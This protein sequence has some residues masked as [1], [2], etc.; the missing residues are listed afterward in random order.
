M[1]VSPRSASNSPTRSSATISSATISS[2]TITSPRRGLVRLGVA[3]ALALGSATCGARSSLDLPAP[4]PPQPECI[5]HEDCP[6][7]DDACKPVRCVDSEKYRDKLPELPAG[8][9]LPPRV[10]FVVEPVL[11]DDDSACTVDACDSA[12]AACTHFP[13]TLDLDDDGFRAPLPGK[14]PGALDA[15]GDDCND[16]SALSF[17]GNPEMCDGVDNDCNGV[18]DDGAEFVP[19]NAEPVRISGMIAPAGPGGL[20]FDGESYLAIY[21]G[22][23]SGFDM[24]ETRISS[25]GAKLEPIETKIALQNADSAG[26]PI[27]WVGDRYG[28]VWQDR[29]DA[30]YEIYFT[31]LTGDGKKALADL[32]LS[33]AFGF[34]I[35][36]DLVWNGNEFIAAWQ[37]ER[38]G[39]FEIVGQRI[40]LD[41]TLVGGNV[42]LAASNG[43]PNEAPNLASGATTLALAFANGAGGQ[44]SVLLRTFD[45]ETL[46]ARSGLILASPTT[47][48]AVSPTVVW[49]DDRYVVSWHERSG[50]NRAV[51]AT[52]FDEDGNVLTPP[53]Q[54]TSPGAARSRYSALTPLGDR[55]LLIWADDRDMNQGYELYSRM[56]GADLSALSIEM[57]LTNAPFD[58]IYP[59]PTFGADGQVGVLF[60]D[61]RSQGEHHVYFTQLGCVTGG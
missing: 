52:S 1:F 8:V 61:D 13:A 54:L 10:C 56:I 43:V 2:A 40:A 15:C 37:D 24:Y 60:R 32:R 21:T 39:L 25:S 41:G 28:L 45:R 34:S 22:S 48:E 16:A 4:L 44:Q 59:V 36:P 58:S 6:G 7:H 27:V 31:L 33:N 12:T 50:N 14:Q 5:R 11:C 51:F 35:N 49:N 20:G 17:P 3:Y 9:P 23:T 55:L 38:T 53:T 30:D 29:R 26:G 42:V 57:R 47:V 19:I 46:D 18:V